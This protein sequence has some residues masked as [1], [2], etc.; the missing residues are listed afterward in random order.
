MARRGDWPRSLEFYDR[1]L[2][3][4]G[5]ERLALEVERVRVLFPLGQA[6]PIRDEL[7]PMNIAIEDGA[8]GTRWSVAKG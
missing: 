5:P 8:Q 3:D 6:R 4:A 2:R 7:A 1:A